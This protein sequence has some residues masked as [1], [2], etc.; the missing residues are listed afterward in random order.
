MALSYGFLL[1]R[2]VRK[3]LDLLNLLL[4]E[5]EVYKGRP[6]SMTSDERPP[7]PFGLVVLLGLTPIGRR[8]GVGPVRLF[9]FFVA[10][11]QRGIRTETGLDDNQSQSPTRV[12][13]EEVVRTRPPANSEIG[14]VTS[15]EPPRPVTIETVPEADSGSA[16]PRTRTRRLTW[17]FA[18]GDDGR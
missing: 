9:L 11:T 5:V 10:L 6:S 18:V 8:R 14:R 1:R 4:Q 12:L 7:C 17:D 16:I 3:T 15:A 2:S 13:V